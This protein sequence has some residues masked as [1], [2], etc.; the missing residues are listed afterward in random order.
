MGVLNKLLSFIRP[1]VVRTERGNVTAQ[2]DVVYE[3]GRKVL[4]ASTVNYSFGALHD[5]FRAAIHRAQINHTQQSQVLILG[6]G[7]G[8]IAH[9][10]RYELKLGAAIT[11]VDA[12]EVVLQLAREE[13]AA[14]SIEQLQLV[15]APAEVYVQHNHDRYSLICVD[16]FVEG[17]VPQ[18]CR[19]PEFIANL[20]SL[21]NDKGKLIFNFMRYLPNEHLP[22]RNE[23]KAVFA[24]V[25]EMVMHLGDADN[26]V[27]ICEKR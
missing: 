7:A 2:L 14:D 26:V 25:D 12:D 1:V 10:L 20:H 8:S 3:N 21:L 9:I 22:L 18:V 13:F 15:C 11:G 6:F 4:H 17:N 23:F 27:W 16:V 24:H 5:V 19:T